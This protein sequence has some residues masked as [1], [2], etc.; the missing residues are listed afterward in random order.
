[1]DSV[2]TFCKHWIALVG[3]VCQF[4]VLI[5][6]PPIDSA[7]QS[8]HH[9]LDP[10]PLALRPRPYTTKHV[11]VSE[12]KMMSD[13]TKL[14]PYNHTREL[15][16]SKA[17]SRLLVAPYRLSLHPQFCCGTTTGALIFNIYNIRHSEYPVGARVVPDSPLEKS[18]LFGF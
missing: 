18:T 8:V 2:D 17:G 14:E 12:Q 11:S 10:L 1:M 6:D 7:A 16:H 4:P 5:I 13:N 3:G 9:V 15:L